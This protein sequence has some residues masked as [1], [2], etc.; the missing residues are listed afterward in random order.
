[1]AELAGRITYARGHRRALPELLALPDDA[2]IAAVGAGE[3]THTKSDYARFDPERARA[4]CHAAGLAVVCR[5]DAHYPGALR[6]AADAAPVLHV[7]GCLKRWRELLAGP[8]VAVV[9]ARRASPYGLEVARALGRGLAAAGATVVSGMALGIDAA[10]HVG[11]LEAGGS[12][13]AVLA[14]GADRPY[15]A[16]KRSLFR[17]IV[18]Q[19]AVASEMPPG[20]VAHRWCFPARNRT[21]AGLAALTIVVE[22]TERSGSL[23]TAQLARDL[24]RDV[25]AVPGR[26]T[27]E[28]AAGTNA[29]LYDGALMVR[30]AQDVLDLLFGAGAVHARTRPDPERLDPALRRVLAA[31]ADGRDTVSALIALPGDTRHVMG[32]LAELELLGY[33][34][35]G[36]GGRYACVA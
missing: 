9:G 18:R 30:D 23:I 8:V 19:G 4:R 36:A 31:V 20:F 13:I 32:A 35:R 2:L 27:S 16:S 10:A 1:M 34:R 25:A 26:V 15:P 21:I 5:H 28:L 7:A 29:L 14:G 6:V 17:R 22:A 11:A 24:G 33:L 3:L 12:T